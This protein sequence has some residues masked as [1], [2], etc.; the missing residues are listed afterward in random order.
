MEIVA[1]AIKD[2]ARQRRAC[3]IVGLD[4]RTY[5]RW[6]VQGPGE[7]RRMGPKT[8]PA[9][10]LNALERQRIIEVATSPQFRDMSPKQIVPH[11]ADRGEYLG[12]ESSFYRVLRANDA[13]THRS[14]ARRPTAN[15]PREH[16]ATGTDQVWSWDI[17][18]LRSAVRGSFHYLYLIEDVWSRKIVG[19]AVHDEEDMELAAA[20]ITSATASRQVDAR[21]L[22]LHSDNGGPMKGSTMLATLQRLGIVASFSR[23]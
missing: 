18:Y 4:V 17:T 8:E 16:V 1:E 7:D 11:L 3:E 13:M 15:A 20:L 5:Q 19:W 21:K 22:V 2:G 14:P 12:S 6:S 9:N 10:K 23:P